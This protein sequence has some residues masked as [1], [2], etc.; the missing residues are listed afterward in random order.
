MGILFMIIRSIN[1]T[2]SETKLDRMHT[3][4]VLGDA[5]LRTATFLFRAFS[6][7]IKRLA[8]QKA[9]ERIERSK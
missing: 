1:D 4:P 8:V 9:I 6:V 7:A 3:G 2:E 5:N